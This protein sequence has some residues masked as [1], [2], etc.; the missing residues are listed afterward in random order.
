MS[1]CSRARRARVAARIER[2][3]ERQRG[4]QMGRLIEILRKIDR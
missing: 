4:K 2:E 1:K 3:R